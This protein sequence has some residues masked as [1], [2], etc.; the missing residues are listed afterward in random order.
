MA[1]T[2]KWLNINIYSVIE[3][4]LIIMAGMLTWGYFQPI[5]PEVTAITAYEVGKLIVLI[6]AG[7]MLIIVRIVNLYKRMHKLE[8]RLSDIEAVQLR[9]GIDAKV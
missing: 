8:H 9:I 3:W 6:F 7:G 5:Q 2:I 4:L 1:R